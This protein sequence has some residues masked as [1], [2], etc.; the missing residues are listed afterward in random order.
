MSIAR[1]LTLRAHGRQSVFFKRPNESLRHVLMKAGLWALH[2]EEHPN[3]VVEPHFDD[4]FRPDLVALGVDGRPVL[5]CE[6]GQ[7]H[8]RKITS[9]ARRYPDTR[10]VIAK[11]G[12]GVAPHVAVTVRAL[13]GVRRRAGVEV[14]GMPKDE[15]RY[16]DEAGNVLLREADVVR[17][18]VLDPA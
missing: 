1:K 16:L 12:L 8:P 2:L 6:A 11:W 17:E 4:R 3:L 10:L 18:T 13:K 14:V 9:V 5:W 15:G 7:L